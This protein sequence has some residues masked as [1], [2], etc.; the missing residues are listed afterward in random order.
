MSTTAD[1]THF[2]GCKGTIRLSDCLFEAM[3]DDGVN[4]K[5]GLYL[6]LLRRLNANTIEA[7]HN[8][9]MMDTHDP[10]DVMEI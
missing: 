6:T 8:L 3:G 4:I 10:G 1:A 5:S 7:R 9:R 2:G